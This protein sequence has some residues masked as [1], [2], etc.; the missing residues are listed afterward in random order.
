MNDLARPLELPARLPEEVDDAYHHFVVWVA[1]RPRPLPC[2]AA[3][4]AG[5]PSQHRWPER[6]LAWDRWQRF[7][8]LTPKQRFQSVVSNTLDVLVLAADKMA[9]EEAERPELRIKP[10]DYNAALKF[11]ADEA[12]RPSEKAGASD[13]RKYATE[14][15]AAQLD[16][17]FALLAQLRQR[18]SKDLTK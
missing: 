10:A 13:L 15:E 4:A 5:Y 6:A 7:A 11:F 14:D 8:H 3:V 12:N 2:D 16:A 1:L 17:A 9:Q 18:A